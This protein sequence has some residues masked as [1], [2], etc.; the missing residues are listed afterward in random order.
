MVSEVL[1]TPERQRPNAEETKRQFRRQNE[2]WLKESGESLNEKRPKN[3]SLKERPRS[4]E[5]WTV[6]LRKRPTQ[7]WVVPMQ[8]WKKEGRR[9]VVLKKEE[10]QAEES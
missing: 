8:A 3:E 6:E 10:Q 9:K 5:K 4:R 2:L 7:V 1:K